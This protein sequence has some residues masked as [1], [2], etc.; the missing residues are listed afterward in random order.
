[1]GMPYER[2]STGQDDR[3]GYGCSGHNLDLR[4]IISSWR[5]GGGP[6]VALVLVGAWFRR[7]EH[8]YILALVGTALTIAG[9]I[10]SPEGVIPWIVLT[11]RGLA[12][13]AIWMTAILLV[14]IR[15]GKDKLQ[16]NEEEIK[17]Y[18]RNLEQTH[19]NLEQQARELETTRDKLQRYINIVNEHVIASSTDSKGL[20]T[21]ASEA[22][23]QKSGYTNKELLGRSHNIIRHPDTPSALY[24]ELW[25]T[26]LAGNSWCGELRN[27]TKDGG[28]YWVDTRIEPDF[29]PNGEIVGFTA[30]RHDITDRKRVEK[31]SVT[32]RLT[33]LYNRLKLDE[34][35]ANELG[36]ATRYVHPLS[37]IM[38]DIDY[39]KSVNDTYGHQVGDEVLISVARLTKEN[40][41]ATD[42]AGRWGGEEFLIIC[43]DTA[44]SGAMAIADKI[45]LAIENCVF[46]KVGHKTASFGVATA[47]PEDDEEAMLR[48]ADDALFR[49]KKGG[50]NLVKK[51][52]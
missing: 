24:K 27:R 35:F 3:D 48:R 42:V 7:T 14:H 41:R 30:I 36:R 12:L 37:V 32:D 50:R 17:Y 19:T 43:P 22:F 33:G 20:I 40:I 45:R 51:V 52:I 15:K 1:M 23:C 11:N 21:Y 8:V 47:R 10:F 25:Q 44:L 46:P 29:G 26:I 13:F 34:E 2:W 4:L 39:F 16:Q 38:F 5:C 9:Y 28:I 49:A 31:L 18:V 6:Y